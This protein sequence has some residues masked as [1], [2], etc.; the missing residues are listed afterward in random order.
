[1]PSTRRRFL[2]GS[3]ITVVLLSRC[4]R[5]G[6]NAATVDELEVEL[7]NQTNVRQR[8]HFAVETAEGLGEWE[9]CESVVRNPPRVTTPSRFTASSMT[10]RR[11]VS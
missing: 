6:D 4:T 3:G 10:T 2:I 9:S 5:F 11:A 1:M 8:F 7:V